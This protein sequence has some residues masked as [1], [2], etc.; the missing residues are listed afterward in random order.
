MKKV[1]TLVLLLKDDSI[2]L[3][4]KKRGFGIN[5]WNGFGGKVEE[6]ETIEQAAVREVNEESLSTVQENNLDKIAITNFFFE[7][8]KH[9]EVHTYVCR[10]WDGEPQETEEMRPEWFAFEDIPYGAMWTPDKVWI[11][12]VLAGE[13]LFGEVYFN[14]DGETVKEME[15]TPVS[16]FDE[17]SN[18][19]KK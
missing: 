9:L 17:V 14:S 11:P 16:E 7:D 3:A 8:G 1:H 18:E 2:C 5:K 4:I 15:W 10:S 6:G 13:K 12:R 19:M